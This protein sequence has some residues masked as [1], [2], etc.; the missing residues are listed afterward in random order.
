MKLTVLL[1]ADFETVIKLCDD[2]K[3][4]FLTSLDSYIAHDNIFFGNEPGFNA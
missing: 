2:P 3:T 1:H 4:P